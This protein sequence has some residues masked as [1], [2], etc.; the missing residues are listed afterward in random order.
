MTVKD[1]KEEL[2]RKTV[3][4]TG[5]ISMTNDLIQGKKLYDVMKFLEYVRQNIPKPRI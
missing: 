3:P 5:I 4:Y 2:T 1:L